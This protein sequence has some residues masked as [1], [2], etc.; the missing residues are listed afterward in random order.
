MFKAF[1]GVIALPPIALRA[2]NYVST[3]WMDAGLLC[4]IWLITLFI[5]LY[6]TY[7][8]VAIVKPFPGSP[9][10]WRK[11]CGMQATLWYGLKQPRA[12][13]ETL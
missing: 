7:N 10:A 6:T 4:K 11:T 1:F 9:A 2:G 8:R 12:C 3:W 13:G 5:R